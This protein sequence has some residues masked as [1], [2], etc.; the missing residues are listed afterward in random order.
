MFILGL[1]SLALKVGAMYMTYAAGQQQAETQKKIAAYNAQN[2]RN[3]AQQEKLDRNAAET[4]ERKEGRQKRAR[5]ESMYAASGVLVNGTSAEEALVEQSKTD[6]LNIL[7]KNRV[8]KNRRN[9]L[10]ASAGLSIWE[11]NM[12]AKATQLQT[13]G[14]LVDQAGS[15]F[16]TASKMGAGAA[17][18]KWGDDSK[19]FG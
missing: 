9:Q 7:N 18:K 1:L 11:G 17:I 2:A 16:S 3:Q 19:I 12:R 15:I 4:E 5:I 14:A 10:E 13:A 8:S 6:E